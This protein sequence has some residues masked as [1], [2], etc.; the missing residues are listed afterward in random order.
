MARSLYAWLARWHGPLAEPISRREAVQQALAATAGLFLSKR[1]V[2]AQGHTVQP[3]VI[4]VGAGL[5]GLAC[6]SELHAAG[7]SVQVFEARSRLG[8]RVRSERMPR[9][10]LIVDAGG[11]YIGANHPTWLAYA[12]RFRLKLLEVVDSDAPPTAALL[13]SEEVRGFRSMLVWLQLDALFR[14]MVDEARN[15]NA[16]EPWKSANAVA[17]DAM[18]LADFASRQR[19]T[20]MAQL[21]FRAECCSTNGNEPAQTSYLST[22]AV[23]KAH[24]LYRFW[25][26]TEFFRCEGGT[27][28]L[29]Q[30][31]ASTLPA[32]RIHLDTPLSEID[33]NAQ[34]SRVRTA[35]GVRYE[36]DDVVLAVPPSVWDRIRFTPGLPKGLRPQMGQ[37]IKYLAG[38]DCRYWKGRSMNLLSDGPL[39]SSWEQTDRQP[40]TAPTV[41]STV[42][43]GAAVDTV[44]DTPAEKRL[45]GY[46][47]DFERMSPGFRTHLLHDELYDWVGEPWSRGS[48]SNAAPGQV[49][50]VWPIL[51]AGLGRL[52][53]AGEH[54]C[55]G[56]EGYMEGALK[57]GLTV[58]K[59][60][61]KRDGVG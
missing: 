5:A 53:F 57:S 4:V 46:R 20:Q 36:A 42:T 2:I 48:Y 19:L 31:L 8:G 7:Y 3:R 29:A 47:A 24:G 9:T 54:A 17:L 40:P 39:G 22:L 28:Q 58:A 1:G 56:F 30:R 50:A 11:E 23:I 33:T 6:A 38:L 49:T 45:D 35:G 52:H 41:L 25:T 60:L 43:G 10:G 15:I 13:G 61:A 34:S 18:T 37:N 26:D 55:P 12:E 14:R 32:E 16:D 51:H 44:R 27:A 21:A 59:G